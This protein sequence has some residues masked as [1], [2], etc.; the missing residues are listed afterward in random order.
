MIKII[1]M[2]LLSIAPVSANSVWQQ[3]ESHSIQLGIRNK[4]GDI[5]KYQVNFIVEGNNKKYNVIREVEGDQWSFV[6]FPGDFKVEGIPN[7]YKW[8]G[9]IGKKLIAQGAFDWT[10]KK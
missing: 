10:I 9:Y 2:L 7:K 4:Y 1:L 3:S 6:N 8:Y 5:R